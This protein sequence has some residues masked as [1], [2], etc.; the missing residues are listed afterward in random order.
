MP[1]VLVI[2]GNP[3]FL[4]YRLE[5]VIS[6]MG[7]SKA[8]AEKNGRTN[9]RISAKPGIELGILWSKGRDLTNCDNHA[10]TSYN[11]MNYRDQVG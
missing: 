10:N 8:K 7:N 4:K 11:R 2:C 5:H 9:F 3:W 1:F 6:Q